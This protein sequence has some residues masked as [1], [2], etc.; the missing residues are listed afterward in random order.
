MTETNPKIVVKVSVNKLKCINTN[1]NINGNNAGNVSIGNKGA[2]EEGYLG[3]YSAAS[4]GYGGE[5]YYD[6]HNDKKD[7][8]LDN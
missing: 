6:G 4:S 1:I 5:G 2:A 3:A 8:G 7:K